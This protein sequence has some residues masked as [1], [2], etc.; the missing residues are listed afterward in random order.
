MS[1][2]T[3]VGEVLAL[4]EGFFDFFFFP[5]DDAR[6]EL[7]LRADDARDEA[8]RGSDEACICDVRC[9]AARGKRHVRVQR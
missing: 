8:G 2:I 7:L 9:S 5:G 1:M 4:E 3:L 6:D